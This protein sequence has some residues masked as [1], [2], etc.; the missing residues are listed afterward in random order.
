M[1]RFL[2]NRVAKLECNLDSRHR[3]RISEMTDEELEIEFGELSLRLGVHQ[4]EG[5]VNEF[6]LQ[7]L[8]E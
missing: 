8:W 1:S 4:T 7:S 6:A 3:A 2:R 5:N